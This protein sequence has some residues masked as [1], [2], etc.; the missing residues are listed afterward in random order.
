MCSNDT[1]RVHAQKPPTPRSQGSCPAQGQRKTCTHERSACTATAGTS[2]QSR[3]TRANTVGADRPLR[4]S[5]H[6]T[7]R[8]RKEMQLRPC[9]PP[10]IP[11][12]G[13]WRTEQCQSR[14]RKC[15]PR[16]AS[17]RMAVAL[18]S[19]SHTSRRRNNND[20]PR[21]FFSP[22][23]REPLDPSAS[24]KVAPELPARSR[25]SRETPCGRPR[26][27]CGRRNS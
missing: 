22:G 15:K 26:L 25:T 20:R 2:N 24:E 21:G 12:Q 6:G 3:R 4:G 16:R 11:T 8:P 10:A 7:A 14:C 9:W 17:S 27:R 5:R 23:S 19:T 1:T 18:G 13:L